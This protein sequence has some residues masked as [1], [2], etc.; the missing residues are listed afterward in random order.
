MLHL[1]FEVGADSAVDREAVTTAVKAAEA[2]DHQV[3]PFAVLG[4]K[5]QFG[6]MALGPDLWRL[7]RLQADLIAAGLRLVNS[8]VSLT[9]VSEYA[10]GMPPERLEPRLHPQLPPAESTVLCFYPMSK[11][12]DATGNWY[13]RP[14]EERY[15]LMEGHGRVGR[16]YRGRVVQLVTGSTGLDDWE[17]GVTLFAHEPGALKACVHEMRFD[18]ASA[19]YAEFGPFYVGLLGTVEDVLNRV[20][21][22]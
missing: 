1:F 11:R 19:I 21:T 14:Y 10:R 17:W 18:E 2:D 15:R 12:R 16:N 13:A 22:G 6:V 4:H 7:Q 8:Y 20:G 5:A 3:V 9:E